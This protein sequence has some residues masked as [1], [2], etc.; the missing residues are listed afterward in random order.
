MLQNDTQ[1]YSCDCTKFKNTLYVHPTDPTTCTKEVKR[2]CNPEDRYRCFNKGECRS[3]FGIYSCLCDPG[4][5]NMYCTGHS[6][7]NTT[8]YQSA[9]LLFKTKAAIGSIRVMYVLARSVGDLPSCRVMDIQ[10]LRLE[11]RFISSRSLLTAT[12][13][14]PLV[15]ET[16]IT[17][18][19]E[20]DQALWKHQQFY[21]ADV[22]VPSGRDFCMQKFQDELLC[23]IIPHDVKPVIKIQYPA[24]KKDTIESIFDDEGNFRGQPSELGVLLRNKDKVEFQQKV[25][26]FNVAEGNKSSCIPHMKM[27]DCST[28]VPYYQ[29]D[30]ILFRAYIRQSIFCDKSVSAYTVSFQWRVYSGFQKLFNSDYPFKEHTPILKSSEQNLQINPFTL[31]Q[32][33]THVYTVSTVFLQAKLTVEGETYVNNAMCQ[34]RVKT[35]DLV[36]MISGGSYRTHNIQ[37]DLILNAS[38]CHD[39]NEPPNNQVLIF[40]WDCY[41]ENHEIDYCSNEE[42]N[43]PVYIIRKE[44]LTAG[45]TLTIDLNVQDVYREMLDSTRQT[46]YLTNN[47][48]NMEIVCIKNCQGE[49]KVSDVIYLKCPLY[50]GNLV[51]TVMNES[52]DS[53]RQSNTTSD[54]FI[55]KPNALES[56]QSYTISVSDP[57]DPT[58][59]SEIQ[60]KT[61]PGL[62]KGLCRIKPTN[63]TRGRTRFNVKCEEYESS[64]EFDS[65]HKLMYEFY[66][67]KGS[68]KS[69][70]MVGFNYI[71]MIRAMV[72]VDELVLVKIYDGYG[73]VIEETLKVTLTDLEVNDENIENITKIVEQTCDLKDHPSMLRHIQVLTHMLPQMNSSQR[74]ATS[75]KIMSELDRVFPELEKSLSYFLTRQILS[76]IYYLVDSL[77]K[78]GEPGHYLFHKIV[79]YTAR[80]LCQATKSIYE[81]NIKSMPESDSIITDANLFETLELVHKC[82]A[83][84]EMNRDHLIRNR[85]NTTDGLGYAMRYYNY[86]EA[87]KDL[88]QTLNYT[89]L[90][91]QY[92]MFPQQERVQFISDLS[93]S[94][95]WNKIDSPERLAN[96]TQIPDKSRTFIT[97]NRQFVD[98]FGPDKNL[99]LEVVVLERNL[100]WWYKPGV[101]TTI[102]GIYLNEVDNRNFKHIDILDKPV[103][104]HFEVLDLE[105]AEVHWN[106]TKAKKTASKDE[107]DAGIGMYLLA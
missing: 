98:Q 16:Y 74:E 44:K 83:L 24:T 6:E 29:R 86:L 46:I 42:T 32:D 62:K 49:S 39:P 33:K 21:R 22:I 40:V 76:T 55:I 68:E 97:L 4:A 45:T 17:N 35:L 105:R 82:F 59:K 107:K 10:D 94:I 103:S 78:I 71:G 57:T 54:V 58:V 2:F 92:R 61:A 52:V 104:I 63:G 48:N 70:K 41:N 96:L 89:G 50:D 1:G 23:S 90:I 51:W 37:K 19:M 34:F 93:Q 11:S 91:T 65:G 67:T 85:T 15:G 47:T 95:I 27:Q 77:E 106:A 18:D 12:K 64:G 73:H 69:N 60:I 53:I 81:R 43:D 3:G 30:K 56:G 84:I 38:L 102:C 75:T 25:H 20:V 14:L 36:I 87:S 28:E 100:F 26:L 99:S 72:L 7:P 88:I 66:Q 5:H 13:L 31:Y 101:N 8:Y 80:H 79:K 9:M